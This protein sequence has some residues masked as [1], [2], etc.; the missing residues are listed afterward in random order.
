MPLSSTPTSTSRE[1][2]VT[3]CA[4]SAL[5]CRM[6][7]CSPSRGSRTTSS[8]AVFANSSLSTVPSVERRSDGV[9]VRSLTAT[10]RVAPNDSTLLRPRR[11]TSERKSAWVECATTTPI[12]S[13]VCTTVPPACSTTLLTSATPFGVARLAFST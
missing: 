8:A 9:A 11:P 4:W 7:H 6:S 3:S 1:P 10:V 5:M 13:H 12:S 2:S